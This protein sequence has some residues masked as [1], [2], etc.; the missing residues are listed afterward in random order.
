MKVFEDF[1]C[2]KLIFLI[3]I[4]TGTYSNLF[5]SC[6]HTKKTSWI[7]RK[8]SLDNARN[9]FFFLISFFSLLLFHLYIYVTVLKYFLR[10]HKLNVKLAIFL[11]CI[12]SFWR[13]NI[14]SYSFCTFSCSLNGK[15]KILSEC[16]RF[17]W[18]YYGAGWLN[19]VECFLVV[20]SND[21][22][23]CISLG[24]L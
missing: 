4:R 14:S 12:F 2:L 16:V 18:K 13:G 5:C 19:A 22:Q 21:R 9:D 24:S 23:K 11:L 17:F 1:F 6:P 3:I 15:H 20:F 10:F 8:F 7:K